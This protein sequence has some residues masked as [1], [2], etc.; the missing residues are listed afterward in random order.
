MKIGENFK[1]ESDSM[2][3]TLSRKQTSKK[4][5]GEYWVNEAY[6]SNPKAALKYLV[7]ME[8]RETGFEDLA[9]VTKKQEELYQLI[10][11]L[12]IEYKG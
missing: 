10:G 3:V 12:K 6:F 4:T 11:K 9:T 2:N 1:L 8:I 7:D 5:G